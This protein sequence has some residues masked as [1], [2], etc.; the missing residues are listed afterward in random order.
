M[1]LKKITDMTEKE[2][3]D[4]MLDNLQYNKN[5]KDKLGEVFTHP[6]LI[7]KILD[8]LPKSIWNQKFY[9]WLEPT[10]GMG[11]FSACIYLRLMKGLKGKMPNEKERA[12]HII[13][14]MLYMV[15]LSKQNCRICKEW[16]GS[17]ANIICEDFLSEKVNFPN[18]KF[19]C[20]IG[21]PPFQ[22]N[23]GVTSS[24]NRIL[25][26]KSKLY[27]RIFLKAHKLLEENGYL[28][29]IVPDNMFSGNKMESYRVL[30]SEQV[31]FVSFNKSIIDFFPKLYNIS[32][33]YFLLQKVSERFIKKKTIIES[34]NNSSFEIFLQDRPINPVS[35]WTK[36][37]ELLT[38]KYI[39]NKRNTALYN[40]GKKISDYKGNKYKL[41]YTPDKMLSTSNQDLAVGLNI[42]K[43][44]LFLISPE[45]QFKMDFKGQYG[46]GPNT[47]YIP[48][49]I[50]KQGR[51]LEKFLNS[52]DY[53]ELALATRTSRQFLKLAFVEYL[54]LDKIFNLNE[55]SGFTR[56]KRTFKDKKKTRKNVKKRNNL[57][58]YKWPM[59]LEQFLPNPHLGQ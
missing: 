26:G 27:E 30:L 7:N 13:E 47:F 35:N 14:K 53:K 41:I 11:F 5:R 18:I 4:Y 56:K 33:C 45:L 10:A 38:N 15:E 21:N 23:Y 12:K 25:G 6:D 24:G 54:D 20:I 51:L 3:Y 49:T 1:S 40:R 50:E 32:M 16:F 2:I 31:E 8:L 39:S 36:K 42:K 19:D 34:G 55:K 44:V 48:F 17:K 29:F 46:L 22:D 9:K 43:A 59:L 37:T 57:T 52:K 58:K 28:S